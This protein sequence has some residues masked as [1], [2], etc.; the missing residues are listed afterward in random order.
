MKIVYN[1][2]RYNSFRVWCIFGDG[3]NKKFCIEKLKRVTNTRWEGCIPLE[4][5]F[6]ETS[7]LWKVYQAREAS[8]RSFGKE[9]RIV[10][11]EL[12]REFIRATKSIGV[13]FHRIVIGWSWNTFI[14]IVMD[15]TINE[16]LRFVRF[17][18][19]SFPTSLLISLV[20]HRCW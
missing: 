5:A 14:I 18:S 3:K 1:S 20:Y 12:L 7:L 11:G 2:F 6:V 19:S 15:S 8:F 4:C 13:I 10:T 16:P 17:R 9:Q